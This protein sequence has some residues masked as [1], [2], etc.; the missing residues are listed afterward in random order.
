LAKAAFTLRGVNLVP[1]QINQRIAR[2]LRWGVCCEIG[3]HAKRLGTNAGYRVLVAPAD[4][5]NAKSPQAEL[6]ARHHTPPSQV[7]LGAP[8]P[9][10]P[11][12]ML[13]HVCPQLQLE[14]K[15]LRPDVT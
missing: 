8:T 9:L 2:D 7:I 10:Q 4:A 1:Q 5:R 3:N 14:Q 13:T 15:T 11:Q 6:I 12:V